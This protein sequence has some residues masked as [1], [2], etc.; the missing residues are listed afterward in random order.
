M[1]KHCFFFFFG[2]YYLGELLAWKGSLSKLPHF[3]VLN[4]L[5]PAYLLWSINIQKET[6]KEFIAY[7]KVL[8]MWHKIKA[9]TLKSWL[10]ELQLSS[11]PF[12]PM[13]SV[14]TLCFYQQSSQHVMEW[15][16]LPQPQTYILCTQLLY[17][18][19]DGVTS[20]QRNG[21]VFRS[22]YLLLNSPK[23]KLF[24]LQI[25]ILSNTIF[26][27]HTFFS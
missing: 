19:G 10:S 1:E 22:K 8:N 4:L 7:R 14:R 6:S 24:Y 12:Y 5:H 27:G 2:K 9:N 17:Y 25:Y 16:T 3:L 26:I 11:I 13:C 20:P 18:S 15:T 21:K 23:N